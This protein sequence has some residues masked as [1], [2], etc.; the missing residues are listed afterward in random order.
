[1]HGL[2]T[3]TSK[4]DLKYDDCNIPSEAQDDCDFCAKPNGTGCNLHKPCPQGTKW[5]KTASAK[6]FMGMGDALRKQ[7]RPIFYSLCNG[8]NMNVQAW[9]AMTGQSWRATDDIQSEF[10]HTVTSRF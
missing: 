4:L 6:R 10:D 7:K 1:M 8:G 2:K 3:L 9:G 5:S